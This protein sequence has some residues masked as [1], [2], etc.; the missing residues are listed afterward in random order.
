M[1]ILVFQNIP[2]LHII[3]N[4]RLFLIDDHDTGGGYETGDQYLVSELG[5]E[6]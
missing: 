2:N 5:P 3:P 6:Y 1:I 4:L